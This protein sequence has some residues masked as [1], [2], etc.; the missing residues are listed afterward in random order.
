VTPA[1]FRRS[2]LTPAQHARI[3]RHLA[4]IPVLGNID[5]RTIDR[6]GEPRARHRTQFASSIRCH[7]SAKA[8]RPSRLM[9]SHLT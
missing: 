6:R 3:R 1:A 2:D 4:L 7:D 8:G 9:A 5:E